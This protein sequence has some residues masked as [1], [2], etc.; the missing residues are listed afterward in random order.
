MKPL[1]EQQIRDIV[2]EEVR[3]NYYAGSPAIPPHSHNGTDNLNIDPHDLVGFTNIP[4]STQKYLNNLTGQM[5]YGFGSP[6]QLVG[7]DST[8]MS[9]Y[10]NNVTTAQ[11]PIPIVVGN[12]AGPQG[13]FEGGYAPEGT[14]V[15][16]AGITNPILYIRW[17]GQWR[18]V[19]LTLTA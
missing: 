11:Y 2:N 7:G 3:K 17:D 1:T 16:F 13:S 19:A 9:Q 12:G 4:T 15:L 6:Q 5:E 14:L 18:G 8:H 10:L